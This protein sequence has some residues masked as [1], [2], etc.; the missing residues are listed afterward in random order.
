MSPLWKRGA[1]ARWACPNGKQNYRCHGCGRRSRENP[2]PNAY[3]EARCEEMMHAYQESS[4]LRGLTR[5]FGLSG[6]T[7]SSWIKK[8]SSASFHTTLLAPDPEDATSTTLEL[9]ERMAR[10]C[11]KKRTTPGCGLPCVARRDRWLPLQ[12][13]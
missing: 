11:S 7:P 13:S 12:L 8:R 2:P 4:S 10:L 3:P 1:S 5:T 6:A 9:D